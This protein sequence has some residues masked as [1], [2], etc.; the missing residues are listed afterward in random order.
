M[1]D[2]EAVYLAK[3]KDRRIQL[4]EAV[5]LRGLWID[6]QEQTFPKGAHG[7]VVGLADFDLLVLSGFTPDE[8][9][10]V[11]PLEDAER[12]LHDLGPLA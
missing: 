4:T 5:T 11:M 12:K 10:Y 1:T 8:R 6:G 9:L 2:T 3:W 7:R